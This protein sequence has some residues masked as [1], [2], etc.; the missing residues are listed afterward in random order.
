[1]DC[2]T[3]DC[4]YLF[5]R[6]AAAYLLIEGDRA[7][8]I[9]NNTTH[10]VPKLLAALAQHKLKPEHVDYVVITHVHLDHAGG[11]SALMQ[12][13]PNAKLLAHP[14]AARHI[15]DPSRLIA[16]AQHVYGK[17]RFDALYGK[18]D[19]VNESRIQEMEDGSSLTWGQREWRF[20]HT[21]GHANHHFCVWDSSLEAI[22]TGDAFGVQYPEVQKGGRWIFPSTSPTDFDAEAARESI[23]RIVEQPGDRA[24]LTHYGEIRGLEAAAQDLLAWIDFSQRVV[25]EAALIE[26]G[27]GALMLFCL[28]AVNGRFRTEMGK[29]GLNSPHV[30]ELLAIDRELNAAGL[31]HAARKLRS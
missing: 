22:F 12:A 6:Y 25:E 30:W 14:R 26:R 19:P 7:A 21:R 3:I 1:M 18:I 28:D 9:E 10:A 5:P 11:T 13:C 24:F 8:F 20:L 29:R 16:S 27:E 2:L 31:A 17:E 4:D 23:R 15:R